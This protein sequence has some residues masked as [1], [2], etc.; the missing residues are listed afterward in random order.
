MMRP[1][2][3]PRRGSARVRTAVLLLVALLAG[4]S[5]DAPQPPATTRVEP[6]EGTEHAVCPPPSSRGI[7]IPFRAE[8]TPDARGRAVG[9][10]RLDARSFLWVFASYEDT[11][12]EDRV[13]RVNPVEVARDGAN[14]VHVCTR[15]DIATPVEVDVEPRSYDVAVLLAAQG[16]LPEGPLRVAISWTAGCGTG[17]PP[18][19]GNATA[20][21][22]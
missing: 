11:L 7:A 20:R 19:R 8:A 18:P 16:D 21:F 14:L 15:V 5:Q 10:H 12:R 13:T 17:C 6:P 22:D 1:L 2:F 4:C 9:I 3:S